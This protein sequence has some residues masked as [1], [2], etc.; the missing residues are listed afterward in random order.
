MSTFAQN[1]FL[2]RH[3]WS[4][5]YNQ[6]QVKKPA[7][8][9]VGTESDAFV[10]RAY[11][12]FEDHDFNQLAKDQDSF[13]AADYRR[14]TPGRANHRNYNR[15]E[16]DIPKAARGVDKFDNSMDLKDVAEKIELTVSDILNAF[17][18]QGWT[19]NTTATAVSDKP[20]T[21]ADYT[22]PIEREVAKIQKRLDAAKYNPMDAMKPEE[23]K[24]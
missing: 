17:E 7:I 1:N 12:Q 18:K 14:G 5:L 2:P 22:T 11:E 23:N 6:T 10:K 19:L 16:Y 20:I 9:D 15:M 3:E 4:D 24:K 8:G 21:R 13:I